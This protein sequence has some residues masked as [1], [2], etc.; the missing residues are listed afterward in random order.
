M[1]DTTRDTE[2][3]NKKYA[4][5]DLEKTFAQMIENYDSCNV[6]ISKPVKELTRNESL[7]VFLKVKR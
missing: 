5:L 1:H 2:E 3:L 7:R 6:K 4:E